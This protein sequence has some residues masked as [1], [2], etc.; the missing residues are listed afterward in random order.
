MKKLIK[1]LL[2]CPQDRNLVFVWRVKVSEQG[3]GQI[4][5][6]TTVSIGRYKVL[7]WT[8]LYTPVSEW[9]QTE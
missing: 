8:T 6:K 3:L 1:R 9:K 5:T 2:R 7:S 4:E